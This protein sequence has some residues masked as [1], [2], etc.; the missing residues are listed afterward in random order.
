MIV[1]AVMAAP[2]F[3]VYLR[4]SARPKLDPDTQRVAAQAY[5]AETGS[6]A[7]AEILEAETGRA[8]VRSQLAVALQRCR[9]HKAELLIAHLGRLP[10]DRCFVQTIIASGVGFAAVDA[11]EANRMTIGI[12]ATIAEMRAAAA[13]KRTKAAL[14]TARDRGV[15]LGNPKGVGRALTAEDREKASRA[16]SDRA[17][18]RAGLLRHVLDDLRTGGAVTL[19]DLAA[20]LNAREVP[21]ARGGPWQPVQVGRVLA[22]MDPKP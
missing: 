10:A 1:L 9:A 6:V 19:Q 11:P 3:V 14:R 13:S 16:K 8:P 21:A 12:I 17:R 7:V 22:L 15:R 2:K 4:S 20:G 5:L 18:Q